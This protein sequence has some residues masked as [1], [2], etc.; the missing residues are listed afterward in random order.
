[1]STDCLPATGSTLVPLA[2]LAVVLIVIG[3]VLTRSG[4]RRAH[5]LALVAVAAASLPLS[6]PAEPAGADCHPD[7]GSA[8]AAAS[9]TPTTTSTT[10]PA[11]STTTVTTSTS[12][13][14]STTST[15]TTTTTTPGPNQAPTFVAPATLTLDED[16]GTDAI[17]HHL[18]PD[19][20]CRETP[21]PATVVIPGFVTDIDPGAPDEAGQAVTFEVT[22]SDPAPVDGDPANVADPRYFGTAPSGGLLFD[23]APAVDPDGT[24]RFTLRPDHFGLTSFEVVAVDDDGARSAPHHVDVEV[25]PVIDALPAGKDLASA[26]DENSACI[27]VSLV[28][29]THRNLTRRAFEITGVDLDGGRLQQ[30][31]VD[32]TVGALFDRADF[33]YVPPADQHSTFDAGTFVPFATFTYVVHHQLDVPYDAAWSPGTPVLGA[34]SETSS[35]NTVGVVV[36]P[37]F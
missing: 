9:A 19:D 6:G 8:V 36:K 3:V 25:L 7:S 16:D 32:V 24:L 29:S 37:V 5:L 2:V 14:S 26:G 17:A 28:G 15:S 1:M 22:V 35:T 10:A 34:H 20:P 31:G 27:P 33:C 11:T 12:S 4:A 13:T 23:V 30:A 18:C 21:A